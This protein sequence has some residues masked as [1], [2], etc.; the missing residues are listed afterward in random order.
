MP[1][2]KSMD[3][4]RKWNGELAD[5]NFDYEIKFEY[6]NMDKCKITKKKGGSGVPEGLG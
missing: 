3:E 5:S 1:D 6:E 4:A 2:Q